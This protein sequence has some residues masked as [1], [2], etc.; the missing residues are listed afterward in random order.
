MS[1]VHR[2]GQLYTVLAVGNLQLASDLVNYT[3]T[4]LTL[5]SINGSNYEWP[6][7][8]F[9]E[10]YCMYCMAIEWVYST[11]MGCEGGKDECSELP[12]LRGGSEPHS[13][14]SGIVT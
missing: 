10:S 14:S 13:V 12:D 9:T 8:V 7:Q 11:G 4:S 5:M 3:L 6:N 1:D 2:F